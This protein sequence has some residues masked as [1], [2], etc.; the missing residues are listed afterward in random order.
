MIFLP[1]PARDTFTF[2]RVRRAHVVI[3]LSIVTGPATGRWGKEQTRRARRPG[4]DAHDHVVSSYNAAMFDRG[5]RP[6]DVG[7]IRR[8]R[9]GRVVIVVS[10][11]TGQQRA[12]GGKDRH[13]GHDDRDTTHTITSLA[14]TTLRCSTAVLGRWMPIRIRR[15]RRARVVI[16]VSIVT[17]PVTQLAG[18]GTVRTDRARDAD[19][20]RRR[21]RD[22]V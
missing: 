9:R 12:G 2:R 14:L 15:V 18:G 4:H 1:A 22:R 7:R 11:V 13:D 21:D 6:L 5:S 17:G 16:V 3:G 8:V 10:I 19:P 20:G